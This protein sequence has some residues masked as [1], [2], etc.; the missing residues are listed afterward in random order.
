[1]QARLFRLLLLALAVAA[2]AIPANAGPHAARQIT[3]AALADKIRGG[4]AGQMF[5]VAYGA[6]AEF[7]AL[8][9]TYDLPLRW[10]PGMV[11]DALTQDDLYVEMTF[12]EVLDRVG[13]EA[14][15][16]DFGAAFARSQYN[17]WHAN[18]AARRLLRLGIK[19]PLS[20]NPRY[21]LHA[22]D[23]D[24]QIESDF[25]GLM[26]PGLP[27]L[28][29]RIADRV[30]HVMNYGDGVYGGMFFAGMY[31]A[32][33]F[34]S[35]PRRVVE[36]GLASI[37]RDSGYARVI[38]DVLD[39]ST[40]NPG[41]WRA[42]WQLLHDKWDRDDI[43]ADG[44]LR[45]FNIDARLNGAFVVLGLLYGGGDFDRTIEI[46]TRS[47]QDADCNPSSAAGILGVITGYDAIPDR[48]KSGIAPLAGRKFDYTSYSFDTIVA[49]TLVRARKAIVAAGGR[50]SDDMITVPYQAPRAAR[51]EQFSPGVAAAEYAVA[52]AD[53]DWQGTWN[54]SKD[55]RVASNSGAGATLRFNGTGLLLAGPMSTEG[56]Q[57]DVYIDGR[58]AGPLLDAY[59][60]ERTW[61]NALWGIFALRDGPHE[62]RF[63]LRGAGNPASHGTRVSITR[64]IAFRP[65][66]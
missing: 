46:A 23:I 45:P 11:D 9:M 26:A 15:G 7:R 51:L 25:I 65:P 52:A 57:A 40:R 1:M 36:Q 44:S 30:G 62:L 13:L 37:P 16:A 5:G 14:T 49:S 18:A 35:D 6:P 50:I 56:G 53:W 2:V 34:E 27:R 60:P 64:A 38:R 21:N 20:G 42:T 3:P 58:K 43:D 10:E 12:A 63:V 54:A 4:W 28:A 55:D 59:A 17:L 31:A 22:N 47:G 19:P 61:D 29:N 48:W 33:F 39:W 66:G 8:G 24:F 32:A 41:D